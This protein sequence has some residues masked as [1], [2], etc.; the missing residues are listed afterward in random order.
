MNNDNEKILS[1][2]VCE[3]CHAEYVH[4]WGKK[5]HHCRPVDD[6]PPEEDK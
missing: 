5:D 2:H 3:R 4:E 6:G 1:I